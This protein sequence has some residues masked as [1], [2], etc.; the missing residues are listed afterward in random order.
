MNNVSLH[1]NFKNVFI[2]WTAL[3][4][5]KVHVKFFLQNFASN[6]LRLTGRKAKQSM[7][8]F[9]YKGMPQRG[10]TSI[11]REESNKETFNWN[12]KTFLITLSNVRQ[13]FHRH[14]KNISEINI[15]N[16]ASITFEANGNKHIFLFFSKKRDFPVLSTS[17]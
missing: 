3:L 10:F 12:R 16:L 2:I 4:I 11:L 13:V 8:H 15:V 6:F 1:F 9:V 17:R 5:Y 7:L 14:F